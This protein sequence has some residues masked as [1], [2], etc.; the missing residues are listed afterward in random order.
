MR[1]DLSNINSWCSPR[2]RRVCVATADSYLRVRFLL[3]LW[4]QLFLV[5]QQIFCI[6]CAFVSVCAPLWWWPLL[7]LTQTCGVT[8]TAS[9][10]LALGFWQVWVFCDNAGDGNR[11]HMLF[12]VSLPLPFPV[13]GWSDCRVELQK[14]FC[15]WTTLEIIMWLN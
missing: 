8:L 12:V 3:D 5:A 6:L 14:V 2:V 10:G 13:G 15:L 4:L 1:S 11:I 7:I 9:P